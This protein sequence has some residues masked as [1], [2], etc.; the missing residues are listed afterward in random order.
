VSGSKVTW[1]KSGPADGSR[2]TFRAYLDLVFTYTG[3]LSLD[4]EKQR[5]MRENVRPGNFFVLVGCPGLAVLV[6]D[7]ARDDKDERVALLGQG[8]IPAQDFRL[9]VQPQH[10][11][12]CLHSEGSLRHIYPRGVTDDPV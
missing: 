8:F 10:P 11:C 3:M 6:L 5:P 1:V 2:A 9:V 12:A 4:E 7:V